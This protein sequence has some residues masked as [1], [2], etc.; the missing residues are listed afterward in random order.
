MSNTDN[1]L[2]ERITQQAKA[3]GFDSEL[4]TASILLENGWSVSQSIYY[5][6]KD[7]NVGREL[8]IHAHFP[9]QSLSSCPEVTFRIL[10]SIEVK[11]SKQ[12][13]IFFSS[14]PGSLERGVGYGAL[15]WMSRV[16]RHVLSYHDIEKKRPLKN[17]PRLGRS[18]MSL[19]SGEQQQIKGGVISAFKAAIHDHQ[20]ADETYSQN[21]HDLCF[22]LPVLVVDAPLFECYFPD[23]SAELTAE[24]ID[25]IE[26]V[27]NYMSTSYGSVRS[28]VSITT[29]GNLDTFLGQQ[30]VWEED[31]L[32]TMNLQKHRFG[33]TETTTPG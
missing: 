1:E 17:L 32:A 3:V 13:L 14:K 2:L 20:D 8:D 25:Y 27:Q 4:K 10:L 29:L 9:F 33:Q 6:D 7:E 16:D 30:K 5:I 18:Y 21:S 31:I 15:H 19:K 11:K 24:S 12:P 28:R 22:Y 26:F 23:T